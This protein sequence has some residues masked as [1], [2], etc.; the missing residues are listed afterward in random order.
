[1]PPGQ[2]H[3]DSAPGTSTC[4]TRAKTTPASPDP[5]PG[6]STTLEDDDQSEARSNESTPPEVLLSM[7]DD[8]IEN[9]RVKE[10]FVCDQIDITNKSVVGHGSLTRHL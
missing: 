1:M 2:A 9:L 4:G 8:V 7:E 5:C 10:E 3:D 6:P